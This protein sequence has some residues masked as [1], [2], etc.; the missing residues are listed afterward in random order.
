MSLLCWNNIFLPDLSQ[1]TQTSPEMLQQLS[2][3][4]WTVQ[5]MIRLLSYDGDHATIMHKVSCFDINIPLL[6]NIV[7]ALPKISYF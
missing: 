2:W 3:I 4:Q 7:N 6:I 5:E 1:G